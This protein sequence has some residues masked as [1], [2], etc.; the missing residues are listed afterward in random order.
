MLTERG[1]QTLGLSL[2]ESRLY[3]A[4]LPL[5]QFSVAE[6]ATASAL[7]RPTCY[8]ILEELIRRGL[9]LTIPDSKKRLYKALSPEVLIKQAEYNVSFAKKILPDLE[10]LYASGKTQ[11]IVRFYHGQKGIHNIYEE[12]LTSGIK[13]YCYIASAKELIDM[14]GS[15]YIRDYIHRRVQ[16]GIH[17]KSIRMHGHEVSEKIFGERKQLRDVRFAP[18]DM[19]LPYTIFIYGQ[20]VAFISTGSS[21][22][23]L[24]VESQGLADTMRGLFEALWK[25]SSKK[26]VE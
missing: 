11:P 23:G 4:A 24:V 13:E 12:T 25:L 9:I 7:K 22:F 19:Y 1:L 5:G 18:K 10:T 6:I 17:V 3:T 2:K 16:K 15:E 8:L 26:E 14:A 20:K 21:D